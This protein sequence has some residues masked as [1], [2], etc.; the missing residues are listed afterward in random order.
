VHADGSRSTTEMVWRS[1]LGRYDAT[2]RLARP[3]PT[4]PM[5]PPK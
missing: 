3:T 5:L 1:D 4:A 2:T